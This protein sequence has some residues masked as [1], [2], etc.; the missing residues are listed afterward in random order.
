MDGN[1]HS[2]LDRLNPLF[3]SPHKPKNHG[4]WFYKGIDDNEM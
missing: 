3:L 1:E 4:C 2:L